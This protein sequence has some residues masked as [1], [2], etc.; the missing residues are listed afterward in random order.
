MVKWALS[1]IK[2]RKI[3]LQVSH[4][5]MILSLYN[6]DLYIRAYI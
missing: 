3:G 1:W 2:I 4:V 5:A 6:T